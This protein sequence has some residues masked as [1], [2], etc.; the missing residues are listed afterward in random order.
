MST[1]SDEAANEDR[2]GPAVLLLTKLYAP[3]VR[4]QTVPRERLLEALRGGSGCRLSL[5]VSPAGFGK[6]TLLAAWR[7]VEATRKPVGWLTLDDGDN[8]P[9]VLWSYVIEALRRV[10]PGIGESAFKA[11]ASSAPIVDVAL[12][13]LVNELTEQG[14]VALILDDFHWLS[15]GPARDSLAWF[16]AHVPSTFQLVVATRTEPAVPLAAL[17][18]HG[19]L[20]ELRADDL[21]FTSEEADAL[22]NDRLELGLASGGCRGSRRA[23]GGLA[24]GALP[25]VTLARRSRRQARLRAQLRR[26]EPACGRFPRGRGAR[27]ARSRAA[28]A[29]APRFCP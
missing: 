11:I 4:D 7:E 1:L 19:E 25:R 2:S 27:G 22:L 15:S 10:C 14:D 26:H 16:V 9:V 5:V 18:A 12:P 28:G 29:D 3:P 24:G 20:L 23:N 8:D 6:S 17:R 21:R 13:R